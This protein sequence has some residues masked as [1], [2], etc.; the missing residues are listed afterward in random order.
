MQKISV[1]LVR[2]AVSGAVVCAVVVAANLG[3]LHHRDRLADA[4]IRIPPPIHVQAISVGAPATCWATNKPI[5]AF[6]MQETQ[7]E[8][9]TILQSCASVAPSLRRHS[10][11]AREPQSRLALAP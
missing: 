2:L 9:R 6:A 11:P 1:D 8:R 10:E 4:E 5:G 7:P 3:G